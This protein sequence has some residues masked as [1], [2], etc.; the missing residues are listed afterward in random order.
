[1]YSFAGGKRIAELFLERTLRLLVFF[2][3]A[4]TQGLVRPDTRLFLTSSPFKV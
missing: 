1:V 4:K 3:L 2:D